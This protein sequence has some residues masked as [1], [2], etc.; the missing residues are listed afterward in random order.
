M[1]MIKKAITLS[2]GLVMIGAAS[3][4]QSLADAKKAID[5]EQYQKATSM[6]KTLI[7]SNAK[8]GENYFNLGNV[9]LLTDDLDSARAVFTNGVTASPKFALNY[10]GLGHAD[11]KAKNPTSAKTNFDKA[12]E[13]GAKNY[14]TY[15]AIGKSYLE[16]EV[17][18][19]NAALSNLQKA[20]E[21]DSKDKDPE[22]FLALGD[23]YNMQIGKNSEA[24]PWYLRALDVNPNLTRAIVQIGKMYRQAYSFSDAAAQMEKAI[25]IDANYGPAYRE[26]SE[27]DQQWSRFPDVKDKEAKRAASLANMRKYLDLTDKSVDSRIRYAQFLVYANDYATLEKEVATLNV[28]ASNPKSFLVTRLRGYSAVENKNFPAGVKYMNE[29]FARKQDA[30]RI[31]GEDYIILGR[32]LQGTGNDSLAVLNITKAVDLDSTKVEELATLAKKYYAD[33]NYAKAIPVYTKVINSNSKNPAIGMHYFQLGISSYVVGANTSNREA[34]VKAD[35]SFSKLLA[36]LPETEQA[37]LYRARINKAIDGIDNKE[38]PKGLAVPFYEKFITLV[39]VT[40]PEKATPNA[41]N[42][43]DSYNYLGFIASGTDK[44]KAKEY[45]NKALAIDPQNAYAAD[46]LKVLNAPP[47]PAKKAPIK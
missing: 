47:A 36:L 25:A 41:K 21:L 16:Q 30:S 15:L 37:I 29:L 19:Y 2:L 43:V 1:K 27:I 26:L 23:F 34:L 32:A 38:T 45:F 12:L 39:T 46:N 17:P 24:Y 8:E 5:A 4:A 11:L 7:S 9:Y 44:E 10:V 22:T 40:K 42:L 14:Q 28:E 3:F 31:L 35:S 18:D 20:E 33:K 6:L 13:L